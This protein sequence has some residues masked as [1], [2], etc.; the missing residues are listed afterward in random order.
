M[1]LGALPVVEC[2]RWDPGG[3]FRDSHGH[4]LEA[5]T[6]EDRIFLFWQREAGADYRARVGAWEAARAAEQSEAA[7]AE[8]LIAQSMADT[9]TIACQVCGQKFEKHELDDQMR[10]RSCNG[11]SLQPRSRASMDIPPRDHVDRLHPE[12]LIYRCECGEESPG[13]RVC[14]T[15]RAS[16]PKETP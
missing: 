12:S 1:P 13:N 6:K 10:C 9:P 15:C 3:V 16:R 2:N 8:R 11:V 5:S 4:E 14:A 7:E